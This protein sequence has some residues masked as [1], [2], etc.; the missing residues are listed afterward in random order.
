MNSSNLINSFNLGG[1]G[2]LDSSLTGLNQDRQ[3]FNKPEFG[4]IY[5][6]KSM[7]DNYNVSENN[8]Y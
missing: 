5:K 2:I 8:S 7:Q 4:G 3:E 1:P 6:M